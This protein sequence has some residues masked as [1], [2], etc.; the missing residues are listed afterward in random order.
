MTGKKAAMIYSSI[1]VHMVVGSPNRGVLRV[2][3][4]LARRMKAGV[5]GVAASAPMPVVYEEGY[6]NAGAIQADRRGGGAIPRCDGRQFRQ[7][8]LAVHDPGSSAL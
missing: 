7:R 4:G 2:A 6:S 1:M 5:I 3:A 8:H